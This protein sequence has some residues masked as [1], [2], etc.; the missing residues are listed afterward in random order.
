MPTDSIALVRPMPSTPVTAMASTIGGN[1]SS[2]SMKRLTIS[3]SQPP[4][5]PMM[6][7]TGTPSATATLTARVEA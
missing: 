5:K 7:P 4:M 3:S 1:D 2:A 6:R